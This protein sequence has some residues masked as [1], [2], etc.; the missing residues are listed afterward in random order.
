MSLILEAL[1]K[2]E[3][4]RRLGE[5]P[6]LS[7]PPPGGRRRRSLLPIFAGLIALALVAGWWLLR[8]SAAPHD[9]AVASIGKAPP[10][11]A[12]RTTAPPTAT[13]EKVDEWVPNL[14][15]EAAA[16]RPRTATQ[17]PPR[18]NA[19][20]DAKRGQSD[21]EQAAAQAGVVLPGPEQDDAGSVK[22]QANE[23]TTSP[24]IGASDDVTPEQARKRAEEWRRPVRPPAKVETAPE[25]SA[26]AAASAGKTGARA[27][28]QR[29]RAAAPTPALPVVWDLPW[30][31]RRNLPELK[32]TMHVYDPDPAQRF[33]VVND[34]R[35]VEGDTVGD[36]LVLQQIRPDG[37][38]LTY[39]GQRFLYPRDG[40]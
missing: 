30:S 27:P 12:A 38:Q 34:E 20:Q 2:S 25:G 11:A 18:R 37:M 9:S 26:P 8:D 6:S 24:R 5:L 14:S 39:Q 16:K 23:L 22:A 32:L 7:S 17:P 3:Q 33:V 10:A 21:A 19:K 36:G 4:Q 28:Q 35:H 1:K 31:I 13:V 15:R 40:R 29:A